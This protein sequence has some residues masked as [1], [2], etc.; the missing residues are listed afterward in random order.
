MVLTQFGRHTAEA[1]F[2]ENDNRPG[3]WDA[4]IFGAKENG[5]GEVADRAEV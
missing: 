1:D 5:Q 2:H 3:S 4:Y